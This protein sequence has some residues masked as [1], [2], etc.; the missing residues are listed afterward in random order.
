MRWILGLLPVLGLLSVVVF[1]PVARVVISSFGAPSWSLGAYRLF[2]GSSAYVAISVRTFLTAALVTAIC[3]SLAFPYAFLMSRTRGRLRAALFMGAVV[4]LFTSAVVR[5]FAWFVLLSPT[6]P[7]ISDL[8]FVSATT[9]L[10]DG[11]LGAVIVGMVQVLTPLAILPLY[12]GMVN[13]QESQ[14]LAAASLGASPKRVFWRVYVPQTRPGLVGASVLVFVASLGFYLVPQM[15][16]SPQQE[17]LP[18]LLYDEVM[19]LLNYQLAAAAACLSTIIALLVVG[20]AFWAGA[21]TQAAAGGFET[22]TMGV[23]RT[24]DAKTLHHA[25]WLLGIAA[26]IAVFLV[27]PS[28]VT[29]PLSFTG[30]ASFV[31]PPSSWSLRWYVNLFTNAQWQGSLVTSG[32]VAIGSAVLATVLGSIAAFALV[33]SKSSLARRVQ[34]LVLVPQIVPAVV[35]ALAIYIVFLDWGITGTVGGFILAHAALGVP[36]VVIVSVSGFGRFEER[37]DQAAAALGA[38]VARR[39]VRVWFPLLA[40]TVVAAFVLAAVTSL[41]E[42][43]VAFFIQG[44]GVVTLPVQMFSSIQDQVDPTVAAAGSVMLVLASCM[45][46]LVV[47]LRH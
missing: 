8:R 40:P 19:N 20:V 2:L 46:A 25:R 18:Q 36:L 17:L 24:S 9:W 15:L 14:L 5:T 4:P 37:L 44:P 35:L 32:E 16:G 13:I 30:K 7:L 38:G 33:R 29:I 12:A 1:F 23:E 43:M 31:L 34:G 26:A 41:D 39:I 22:V 3:L 10:A 42:F 45:V 6:G 27:V 21:G 28:V 47:L 11:T